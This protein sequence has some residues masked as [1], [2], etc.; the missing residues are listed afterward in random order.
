[1]R[2]R[3][4]I[5][6]RPWTET[7]TTKYNPISR[8]ALRRAPFPPPLVPPRMWRGFLISPSSRCAWKTPDIPQRHRG[9]SFTS[10]W[11]CAKCT[12]MTRPG[13]RRIGLDVSESLYASV[14][15]AA[16]DA[17]QDMSDWLRD[18]IA[19]KLGIPYVPR[20]GLAA[21]QAAGAARP[22]LAE[23]LNPP[24]PDLAAVLGSSC[25]CCELPQPGPHAEGCIKG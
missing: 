15:N 20:R 3:I 12:T 1:M 8:A 17:R 23:L 10:C 5:A 2:R 24:P 14:F 18:A 16:H 11:S 4:T 21:A 22:P 6:I 25:E 19:A 7:C 13:I 9:G